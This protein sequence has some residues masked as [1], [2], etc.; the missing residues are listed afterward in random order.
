MGY[1]TRLGG[2]FAFCGS[3]LIGCSSGGFETRTDE[4]QTDES[5]IATRDS[6]IVRATSAGGRNEVVM[7]YVTVS[8][9]AGLSTRICSGTYFASRV[10][11]TAAHCLQDALLNQVFI[12][13]GD[14]FAQDFSQLVASGSLLEPPAVGQPSSWAQ[15]DSFELHPQ[16]DSTLLYPD[17]AVVYLDR[18]LPFEPL[19]VAR[20]RLDNSSL[21]K[22]ATICGWGADQAST[23]TTGSGLHVQRT[24]KTHILGSP[25][26]ADYHPEDPNPG[27][28]Q[29]SVR[30]NV[31]KTDGHAPNSNTCFGDS[32]GPLIFNKSGQDYVAGVS[33]FTGLSC[34][35]YSLFVRL[36]PF[37]PFI[38]RATKRGGQELLLPTFDCVTQTTT[39]YRAF[40]GYNNK[41][42]VSLSI[43]YGIKNLLARDTAG[44][45][46]TLFMP[47]EHHFAFAVDFAANQ[48]V[49]WML[50]PDNNSVVALSIGANSKKCGAADAQ[51]VE[52]AGFCSAAHN[53]GCTNPPPFEACESE[54]LTAASFFQDVFPQCMPLNSA[55]NQCFA[56]VPGGLSHWTCLDGATPQPVTECQAEA[57]ALYQCI[58]LQ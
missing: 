42:G 27:M 12:Y 56:R 50:I 3:C 1:N 20:F 36:D 4:Q 33:Y 15:A 58:G 8:N 31:I 6:A 9:A 47:G 24:G 57:A 25:T 49:S 52:C 23:P 32:G 30:Q 14:N 34:E 18:K 55:L 7:L 35:D 16:W 26:Q 48:N 54:C 39:G 45:R 5:E 29:A 2:V 17:L 13:Y 10:V 51:A 41:N 38:D 53:S 22:E 21:N 46:P 40:F 43:P 11:L 19:P 37:L 44:L 28:L